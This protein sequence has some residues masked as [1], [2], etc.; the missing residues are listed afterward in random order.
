[1]CK[2]I[3]INNAADFPILLGQGRADFIWGG[4]KLYLHCLYIFSHSSNW[5]DTGIQQRGKHGSVYPTWSILC[6]LMAWRH[7]GPGYQQPWCWLHVP[8]FG[9]EGLNADYINKHLRLVKI[10]YHSNLSYTNSCYFLT[11]RA[12]VS[13][14]STV[15]CAKDIL[16][17]LN[18]SIYLPNPCHYTIHTQHDFPSQMNPNLM[19]GV[20]KLVRYRSLIC[21]C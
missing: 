1:M 10:F 14:P 7:K 19:I 21:C 6:L 11:K 2:N 5:E 16:H 20:N 18:L 17:Y 15:A 4:I 13:Q 9:Q 8:T 3:K 12:L